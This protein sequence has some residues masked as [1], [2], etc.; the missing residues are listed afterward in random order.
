M[1]EAGVRD[2]HGA[3]IAVLDSLPLDFFGRHK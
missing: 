3:T 1:E 2:D